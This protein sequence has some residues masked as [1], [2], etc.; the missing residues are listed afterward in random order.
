MA[1][2]PWALQRLMGPQNPVLAPLVLSTCLGDSWHP[3]PLLLTVRA[4]IASHSCGDWILWAKSRVASGGLSER[5][6]QSQNSHRAQAPQRR[7]VAL[8]GFCRADA[9]ALLLL[10]IAD[11]AGDCGRTGQGWSGSTGRGPSKGMSSGPRPALLRAMTVVSLACCG[12]KY[13]KMTT[14]FKSGSRT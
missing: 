11:G 4:W 8:S 10:Q 1:Q 7:A 6:R 14:A 3:L 12:D 5:N 13:G 9:K 2:L